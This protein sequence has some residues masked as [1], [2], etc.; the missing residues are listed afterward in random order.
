MKKTGGDKCPQC[1]YKSKRSD[2]RVIYAKAVSVVD[3]T[4]RDRALQELCEMKELYQQAKRNEAQALLQQNLARSECDKLKE[5]IKTLKTQLESFA[6]S[7]SS[8]S[9][10]SMDELSSR[11]EGRYF[12]YNSLNVSQVLGISNESV[13]D[14]VIIII[15]INYY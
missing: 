14:I 3:T 1:N 8:T 9:S 5:E 6:S 11:R 2:I 4:D 15:I 7:T 13:T 12:P 10:P